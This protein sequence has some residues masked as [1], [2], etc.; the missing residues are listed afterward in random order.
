MISKWILAIGNGRHTSPHC[1]FDTQSEQGTERPDKGGT[2]PATILACSRPIFGYP[3]T[4][5]HLLTVG[6]VTTAYTQSIVAFL[7]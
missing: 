2:A 5:T 1:S 3:D 6:D 4:P 7:L